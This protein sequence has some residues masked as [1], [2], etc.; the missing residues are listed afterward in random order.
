MANQIMIASTMV[1]LCESLIYGHKAGLELDE[2]ISFLEKEPLEVSALINW[3]QECLR[4]ISIRAF[5]LSISL[6]IWAYA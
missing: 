5:M 2:L 6:R 4:E 1:G 3:P